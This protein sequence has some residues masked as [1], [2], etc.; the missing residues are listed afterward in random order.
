MIKALF[1]D[2]DGVIHDTFDLAFGVNKK[3]YPEITVEEYLDMF[4]GNLYKHKRITKENAEE[5]FELQNQAF[6]ELE[7]E[8]DIKKELLKLNKRYM[9]F[10]I[11]SNMEETVKKYLDKNEITHAFY[12]V[13]G[14]ETHSSKLEKFKKIM[15]EY[16]LREEECL[17]ITDTLGDL[18]EAKKTGIKALAVDYGFHEEER[19]KKGN[20]LRIISHLAEIHPTI[21]KFK[22]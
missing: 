2:F 4:N 14:Y 1:F 19:L 18:L 17:F 11:T 16:N 12:D 8:P 13:L 22:L 15:R 9:M 21:E 5:F 3:L 10:I 6:L 20:P 7:I